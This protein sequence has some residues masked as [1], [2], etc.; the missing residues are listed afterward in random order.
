MKLCT[1]CFVAVLVL[2]SG[3]GVLA[4]GWPSFRGNSNLTGVASGHLPDSLSVLWSF[5][6]DDP[7][8]ST[9]TVDDK[10]VY[11]GGL[12]SKVYALDWMT[13]D[14]RWVLELGDEVKASPT[15]SD[16]LVLLGDESGNFTAADRTTG[17]K[18]WS[19]A[20]DGGIQS[21]ASIQGDNVVFGS[22][23]NHLY[24]LKMSTGELVWK[25]ETDGYVHATPAI[26]D[27]LAFAA[28][29]DGLF[30]GVNVETGAEEISIPLN[31]YVASSPGFIGD[32][33][34]V[35]TFGNQVL[36]VDVEKKEIVW[37]YENTERLFPFYGS[38]AVTPEGIYIGGRDKLVHALDPASG[39][40]LWT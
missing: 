3:N 4:E 2:L 22:Y 39:K 11:F 9:A 13:G 17:E 24:C 23:D 14:V 36:A 5:E 6:I 20:T 12:D 8:E 38:P 25:V 32:V 37:R 15:L 33:A 34:Y 21:S 1:E 19:T 31:D 7:I 27:G 10:S 16:S 26:R 30:R 18:V 28:G 29:C 40:E 35:G